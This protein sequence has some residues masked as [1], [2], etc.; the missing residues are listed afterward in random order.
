MR[1]IGKDQPFAEMIPTP[2]SEMESARGFS[3]CEF[4]AF[5]DKSTNP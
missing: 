3:Q 1:S 4:N 2:L 5:F